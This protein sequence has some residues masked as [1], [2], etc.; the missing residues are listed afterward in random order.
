M[1]RLP[2]IHKYLRR[3][4]L[5]HFVEQYKCK[6]KIDEKIHNV[7]LRHKRTHDLLFTDIFR[8]I[9]LLHRTTGN[10]LL[11]LLAKKKSIKDKQDTYTFITQESSHWHSL[12]YKRKFAN[13]VQDFCVPWGL[14]KTKA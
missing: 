5:F 7:S 1:A 10:Y 11:M 6:K 12:T 9:L 4:T 8:Y 3:A 13:Q 14:F 2:S